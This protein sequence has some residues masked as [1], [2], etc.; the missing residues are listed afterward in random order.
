MI[1]GPAFDYDI[2]RQVEFML[3]G[4]SWFSSYTDEIKSVRTL[5]DIHT[6]KITQILLR[7]SK[8]GVNY[9]I[10][11]TTFFQGEYGFNYVDSSIENYTDLIF[12][13]T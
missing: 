11:L 9:S 5:L 8:A 7:S 2:N 12:Y 10:D 1:F 4:E 6:I 3:G 13:Y